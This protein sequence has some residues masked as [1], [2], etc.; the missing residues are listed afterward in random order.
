VEVSRIKHCY[1]IYYLSNVKFLLDILIT[2]KP[3]KMLMHVE[4]ASPKT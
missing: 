2:L 3:V 1:D 4:G